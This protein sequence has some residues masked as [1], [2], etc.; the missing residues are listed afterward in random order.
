MNLQQRGPTKRLPIELGTPAIATVM[1]LDDD[2]S[3][4]LYI[5]MTRYEMAI[6]QDHQYTKLKTM[7]VNQLKVVSMKTRWLD[8]TN[9]MTNTKLNK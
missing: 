5:Y 8:T 3:G 7:L 1:I 4:V 6:T 2:H 9:K